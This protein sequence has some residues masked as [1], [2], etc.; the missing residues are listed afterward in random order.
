MIKFFESEIT[1]KYVR[2]NFKSLTAFLR[3]NIYTNSEFK[4]IE[5][6]VISGDNEIEHGYLFKPT[7]C[8]ISYISS[9]TAVVKIK[10][11]LST[12]NKITINSNE[13][14]KIRVF[15]GK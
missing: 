2:D 6:D 11:S 8:F 12:N 14:C 15:I 1:D 13:S 5:K 4:I 7:D 10:H 9:D 3:N